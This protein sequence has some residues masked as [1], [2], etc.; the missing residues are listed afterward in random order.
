M[1]FPSLLVELANAGESYDPY[2]YLRLVRSNLCGSIG[3]NS[4]TC[5]PDRCAM[6]L[7]SKLR[8]AMMTDHVVPSF[9]KRTQL[10]F[11]EYYQEQMSEDTKSKAINTDI[12][13][14]AKGIFG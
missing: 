7:K 12:M 6:A 2:T 11:Q 14:M 3:N 1:L 8:A 5:D 10:L 4:L 13:E 9:A